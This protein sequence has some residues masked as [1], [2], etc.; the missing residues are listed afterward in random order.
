MKCITYLLEPPSEALMTG[1]DPSLFILWA[2]DSDLS[3]N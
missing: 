1:I 3:F 2:E